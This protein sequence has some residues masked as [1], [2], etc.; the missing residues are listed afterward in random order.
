MLVLHKSI[1]NLVSLEVHPDVWAKAMKIHIEER[2]KYH[3]NI[4]KAREITKE[5]REKEK[6]KFLEEERSRA[7]EIEKRAKEKER[8]RAEEK[9]KKKKEKEEKR[10]S[11]TPNPNNKF[12]CKTCGKSFTKNFNLLSRD[13]E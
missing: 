4:L 11:K 3:E 1:L 13:F 2:K 8:S 6:E 7:E 5:K 10:K 9:E 12:E